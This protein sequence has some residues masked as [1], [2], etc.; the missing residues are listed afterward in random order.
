MTT[1]THFRAPQEAPKIMSCL[2]LRLHSS[3]GQSIILRLSRGA[4]VPPALEGVAAYRLIARGEYNMHV[5]C[6]DA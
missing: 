6:R 1:L 4:T 3:V 2:P 5:E